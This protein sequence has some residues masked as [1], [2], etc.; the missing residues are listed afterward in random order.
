MDTPQIDRRSMLKLGALALSGTAI[1]T[2]HPLPPAEPKLQ[3]LN[4]KL[5]PV[6]VSADRIIRKFAGLRPYRPSGFVVRAQQLGEKT[7]VHNYGHGGCGITL[8]WGTAD[9]AVTLALQTSERNAAVLGAGAVGLA[10][11]RLLQDRGFQVTVYARDL[12]PNT[13]SNVAGAMFAGTSLLDPKKATPEFII[14]LQHATRFAYRYFQTLVGEKYNVRWVE[15]YF[16]GDTPPE[17]TY[18]QS[19]VPELSPLVAIPP[20]ENPFPS[21]YTSRFYS[22]LINTD[23]YLEA[24][25]SDFLTRGGKLVVNE[26]K[27]QASV[28]ALPEKLVMNCTG[29]GAKDLFGDQELQP[30]KGQLMQLIPQPE[31]QYAYVNGPSDLYMFPRHNGIILGGTHEE[32]VTSTEP[33]DEGQDRI[34]K[35]HQ[36][37]FAKMK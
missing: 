15:T 29:L 12:P 19:V 23:I 24:V 30:L 22:M 7:V 36:A 6:N 1:S 2:P 27:D 34:F 33:T 5:V 8:S 21:K 28:S 18:E 10:T 9:L 11:A 17:L 32:G 3:A 35:G 13:T 26:V 37:F 20:P 25:L 14:Q 4:T 16:V 31:V